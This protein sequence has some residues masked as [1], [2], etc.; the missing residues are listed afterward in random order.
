MPARPRTS[1][2][3]VH[4]QPVVKE[5]Q[6]EDSEFSG[7]VFKV[8]AN[9]DVNHRDRIAFVRMASGKYTPGMKI[10]VQRTAQELRPTSVVTFLS[11]R[12]AVWRHD[13]RWRESVIHRPAVSPP[14]SS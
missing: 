11:Q 12:R 1:N 9:M 8:Q 5:I 4:K 3:L 7:A 14:N 6:P 10:K 13:H 2:L